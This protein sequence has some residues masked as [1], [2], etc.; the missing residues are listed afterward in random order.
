M[1]SLTGESS[2][3]KP[4]TIVII[5]IIRFVW[6]RCGGWFSVSPFWL[7]PAWGIRIRSLHSLPREFGRGDIV[8]KLRDGRHTPPLARVGLTLLRGAAIVTSLLGRWSLHPV[9]VY[10]PLAVGAQRQH[11]RFAAVIL[12]NQ[13]KGIA[14]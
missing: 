13:M 11:P 9:S 4:F 3:R 8:K 1:L 7:K 6:V 2:K 10:S 14:S 12:Q 5:I